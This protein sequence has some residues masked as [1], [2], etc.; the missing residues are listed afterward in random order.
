M[1]RIESILAA[2]DFSDDA[3]RAAERAALLAAATGAS[4]LVLLHVL[5]RSWLDALR[6]RFHADP[7]L[8]ERLV[9][10]A[11]GRLDALAS[12]LAPRAGLTP[13]AR[14]ETGGVADGVLA[15]AATADLLVL[16]AKGVHPMRDL[17]IGSTAHRLLRRVGTPVLVVK[18]SPRGQY[19]RLLVAVDFSPHS[20]RALAWGRVVAPRAPLDLVHLFEVPFEPQMR[21]AGVGEAVIYAYRQQAK[22]AAREE[23]ERFIAAAGPSAD[24]SRIIAHGYAPAGLLDRSRE[25]GADL[26]VAG[27]RGKSAVEEAFLGSVTQHLLAGAR[28]DVLVV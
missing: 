28:C 18:R 5:D 20:A 22:D 13:T 23:M 1:A 21:Y 26:I 10:E 3:A 2:T 19:R 14:V 11:S 15:A 25:L 8:G 17:A 12:A 7:A 6:E 24:V 16:G 4:Q 9:A 27:K